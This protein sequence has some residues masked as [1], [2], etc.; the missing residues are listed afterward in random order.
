M[1][2]PQRF[3][4]ILVISRNVTFYA[5]L[6]CFCHGCTVVKYSIF[7]YKHFTQLNQR[8]LR[9]HFDMTNYKFFEIIQPSIATCWE[10][11]KYLFLL[12]GRFNCTAW[13]AF[14]G[15]MEML[16]LWKR[17][18]WAFLKGT[19]MHICYSSVAKRNET[20]ICGN[21]FSQQGHGAQATIRKCYSSFHKSGSYPDS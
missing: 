14:K 3:I 13:F 20:H 6:N 4:L 11:L 8:R 2:L 1:L 12:R 16:L 17:R 9:F 19:S 15:A 5:L 7:I 21:N 10:Q 18:W